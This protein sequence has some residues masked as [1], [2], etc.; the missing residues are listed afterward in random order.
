MQE[1]VDAC[2][3][4]VH[5]QGLRVSDR[6]LGSEQPCKRGLMLAVSVCMC[7]VCESVIE[8]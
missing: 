8:S 3:Q 1:G 2:S 6:E 7:K 4:Y 5:V